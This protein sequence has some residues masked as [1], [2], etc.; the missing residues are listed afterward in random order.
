MNN[1]NKIL[2][3]CLALLLVLSVGYALFSETIQINGTATAKGSFDI[4]GTCEVVTESNKIGD[5]YTKGGTAT[6][7]KVENGVIITNSSLT[8]PG[9]QVMFRVYLENVG[10]IP[11]KLVTVDSSNNTAGRPGYPGDLVYYNEYL[12]A[13]GYFF[14]NYEADGAMR[15][16]QAE[17]LGITLQPNAIEPL[18]ILHE[19]TDSSSITAGEQP[20]L[21]EGGAVMNYNITLGFEQVVAN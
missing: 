11:A 13:A 8:K 12:L 4:E 3:G 1:K 19:W 14:E 10:S 15:D 6:A 2:V 5:R 7:C 21:P 9:D 17:A 16:S 20:E 18:V